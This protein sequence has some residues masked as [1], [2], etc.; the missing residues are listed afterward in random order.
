MLARDQSV[1]IFVIKVVALVSVTRIGRVRAGCKKTPDTLE[2]HTL[3]EKED[4][5]KTDADERNSDLRAKPK[6]G[7]GDFVYRRLAECLA[8][9]PI[10][11]CMTYKS[12]PPGVGFQLER[13]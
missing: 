10:C 2:V 8:T 7:C 5:G 4:A 3:G 13:W 6:D 12:D 1:V 11:R 9:H